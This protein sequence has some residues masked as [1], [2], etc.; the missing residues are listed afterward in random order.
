VLTTTVALPL[1]AIAQ[2]S[3]GG[4]LM[5]LRLAERFI[6]RD[7]NGPIENGTTQQAI[8][9]LGLSV[10]S[11][12]RTEALTFDLGGGYRFVDGPGRDGFEGEFTDPNVRLTYRQQAAMG[13]LTRISQ[14]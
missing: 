5:Q 13:R 14:M 9:D 10:S 12:T 6:S 11:E 3:E 2:N 4:F 8:T 1:T 7:A